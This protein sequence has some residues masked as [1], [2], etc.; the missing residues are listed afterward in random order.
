[1]STELMSQVSQEDALEDVFY[2]Q[3]VFIG[4][5]WFVIVGA[6]FL[7]LWHAQSV[8]AVKLNFIPLAF[9]I[10]ANFFLHARYLM[11]L[12]ANAILL[13]LASALDL[14]IITLIVLVMTPGGRTGISN[15]F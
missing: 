9:L 8:R 2:G 10:A 11:D 4:A 12:P 7:T 14:A 1:M 13:K 6:I 3:I 5:R 15:P